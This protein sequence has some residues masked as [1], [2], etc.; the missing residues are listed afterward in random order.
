[1]N[2]EQCH[3]RVTECASGTGTGVDPVTRMTSAATAE[4]GAAECITTQIG[5]RSPS[6][7]AGWTC[8]TWTKVTTNSSNRQIIVVARTEDARIDCAPRC[9]LTDFCLFN[10]IVFY[11]NTQIRLFSLQFPVSK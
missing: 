10:S 1:M 7:A 3:G 4:T 2:S 11:K 9:G 5:Q 8:A 6:E